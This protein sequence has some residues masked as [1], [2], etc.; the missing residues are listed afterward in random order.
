MLIKQ[1]EGPTAPATGTPAQ[2]Q[3]QQP[4]PLPSSVAPAPHTQQFGESQR[5]PFPPQ[6]PPSLMNMTQGIA[7]H[8]V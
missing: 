3:P 6:Q 8:S 2:Q 7:C 5:N 1:G 4:P